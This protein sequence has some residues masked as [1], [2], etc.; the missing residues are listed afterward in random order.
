MSLRPETV[1]RARRLVARY[2]DPRSA[3]MPL[4]Y[5]AQADEGRLT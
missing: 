3:V 1:E 2:P 4:L 5:M